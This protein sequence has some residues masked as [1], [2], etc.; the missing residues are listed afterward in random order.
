MNNIE[1]SSFEDNETKIKMNNLK[2]RIL[3][4]LSKYTEI[5]SLN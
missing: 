5:I 2:K 4:L 3:T 1:F